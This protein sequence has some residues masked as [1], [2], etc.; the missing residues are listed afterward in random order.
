[1]YVPLHLLWNKPTC[2]L[3]NMP[4]NNIFIARQLL[5]QSE[6]SVLDDYTT[7]HLVKCQFTNARCSSDKEPD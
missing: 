5:L 2:Y 6:R 3:N 4:L 1:M 7:N